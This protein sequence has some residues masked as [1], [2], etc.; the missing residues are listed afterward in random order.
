VHTLISAL[1]LALFVCPPAAA[2][3]ASVSTGSS[4]AGVDASVTTVVTIDGSPAPDAP[5]TIT[6]DDRR[7]PTVR[8][9]KLTEEFTLD[10][11]LDE[12]VYH[13]NEPFGDFIQVVP[14]NGELA[15]ERTDV[16]V[17]YDDRNIYVSAR[18][19][20]S[21][22]P[23]Q[24]VA[25]E[26][27]RDT[28]QLRNNDQIGV[29]FDTF[30]DRRSGFM[31][32]AN[33]LGGFSDY[34]IVDEGAPN[35]DWNPVWR[36]RT[37]RFDGGWTVEM[38]IPF[39]SIRYTSGTNMVWGFQ[40]RRAIR[41]KNEWAYLS[42]VPQ[43][44][45]GPLA[46]NRVS[47]Y[48]TLVGLDLPP[49]SR[50]MELK[51]Y[52]LGR[53][54][55]DNLSTPPVEG[56]PDSE[57]GGDFKYGVTANL[58]ADLT[59]NTDFAQVEV[60][61]QQVN[62]TRFSL[63]L[64]EK[65]D[66][67]LEGRGNF[68]FARGGAS[69]GFSQTASDTP[70][71]FYSRRIGLN[72]GRVIPIDVGGRLTGKVG[73]WGIG[74]VNIQADDEETSRT[75]AT[76]FTVLRVKRDI[77]RRS[78]IGA[79]YTNRSVGATAALPGRN[80]AYGVDAAFAFY[81]NVAGGAYY[82]RTDTDGLEGDDESYQGRIEW[83]PDRYGARLEYTKVGGAFNP[84][85]G[86]VRRSNFE[87]TQ[88][89]LRFS[90]R[91][92]NSKLVR[93]YTTEATVDYFVNGNGAVETRTQTGRFNIE[94]QSS[95]QVA[96]EASDNYEALFVPFNVGG[97]VTIPVGGYDFNDAI[98][99]YTLG[100]QRRFTGTVALQAGQFYDGTI[101]ALTLGS[102]RYAILKQFSVEPSL[103]IN[104]IDLPYGEFTTK[105]YRARTDYAFSARMF[106]SALLQ[107]STADNTFSSNVRYRW[108]YIPGSEFFLVWTDE[109]DTRPNSLGLRNRAF[110]VKLTRLLRF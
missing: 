12:R 16:W 27:R 59:V 56:D 101:T 14:Q 31:F 35:T 80:Q 103:S 42:P 1:A 92:A 63:F 86:F 100:Q 84:E 20:D 33:P 99:S 26:Y 110:V 15:S 105:L 25:N 7:R 91:P 83:V 65:R 41:R 52:A 81:Q 23:E 11:Q 30:Y 106:L 47:S 61:E 93:K 62:L 71:L 58:T 107:Y 5:G 95:D 87:K 28:N 3:Q 55:T 29:G 38:A 60:D 39:R 24:W 67:F 104:R 4:P 44:L 102:A 72:R 53:V 17:T 34:S 6:R 108:E 8:A 9:I 10:G 68:D 88:A 64:P 43:N 54:T 22:P 75:E 76:N 70:T 109:H 77:L 46:L 2:G 32:Y 57:F 82:A 94:F 40:M 48:G 74:A 19:F 79:I 89:Y 49:A 45:A 50:N 18:V 69:G 66:F 13:E 98:V 90:P 97:G 51:P 36:V 85:V 78:T 21:A 73:G 96:V 37:G